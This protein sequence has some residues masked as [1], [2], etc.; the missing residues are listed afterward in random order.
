MAIHR[1][2]YEGTEFDLTKGLAA[3]P[4]GLPYR[5]S[6]GEGEKEVQGGWERPISVKGV[7][8]CIVIQSRGW[9]P[10]SIGGI[11]WF[12]HN[13]AA[14]TCYVPFY[15]GITGM[16]E[17]YRTGSLTWFTRD[18]S[19][20]AFNFVDNW[21][22][23]KYSYMIKDINAAQERLEGKAF[24]MQPAVEKAAM[25]LY[26][27]DPSLADEYLTKYSTEHAN[28]VVSEWWKL[29]DYLIVKYSD[30]YNNIP[31]V[32]KGVGYPAWWL[33]EV[34]FGPIEKPK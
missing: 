34:G 9:L 16:P 3:G 26:E 27:I 1:D 23:L 10:P 11:C 13:T 17:A 30:G 4:F 2:H 6:G 5:Y 19:W 28:Y 18:S 21:A 32:G 12:G 29:A 22:D 25:E 15:A 7:S 20:W 8:H 14:T 33:K 31:R 24:A